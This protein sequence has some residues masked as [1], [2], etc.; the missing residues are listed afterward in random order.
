MKLRYEFVTNSSS[1][2]YLLAYKPVPDMG[3]D[4]LQN[5]IE[6]MMYLILSAGDNWGETSSGEYF[7]KKEEFDEYL[8]EEWG[9]TG[10]TVEEIAGEEFSSDL[11]RECLNTFESG[12]HLI[13]K[14]V[15]YGDPVTR[16]VINGLVEANIGLTILDKG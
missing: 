4:A 2:S 3:N 10:D 13:V 8:K 15:G 1:S 11:Y 16:Q 9:W 6:R 7:F 12:G 5:V 14:D